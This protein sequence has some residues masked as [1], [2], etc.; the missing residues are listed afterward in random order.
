M[1]VSWK[2][3]TKYVDMPMTE[4]ELAE[5]LSLTGLNHEG[6]EK[7]NGDISIDLEV[8]SN[9]GDCLGH[10]G[11]A[12]EISVLYDLPLNKP[13][14]RPVENADSVEASIKVSN[15]FT[16][17]CPRY[18]ARVIRGAKVGPSPDWLVEL[19]QS[20]HWKKNQKT[21]SIETYKPINNIVDITN[22]VLY[23]C[24]QPLH[25]F[26]LAKIKGQE[27][28]VRPARNGEVITA[29][30]HASYTL[31]PEMCVIADRD[32]AVAVAGVMG[33]ADTEV[34]EGTTDLLIES[35]VFTPLSVRRTARKLKLHSPSSFRFERKVDPEGV[36]WASRRC[37]ELILEIAGGTLEA[38]SVDT[39]PKIP[40]RAPIILRPQQVER[41]LGIR[42][43]AEEIRDILSSL[44]CDEQTADVD[45]IY[46]RPPS[47]RHD[48]S[49][50]VDL[51]E[52][53][54]RIHGYDKI[55]DDSPIPTTAS[56]KR[57]H[58][59]AT[60]K[61]RA[62]L[63]S[64]GLSEAMTPSVVPSETDELV[65]PWSDLPALTTETAMLEGAKT[66]RRSIIP[67]L[68]KSRYANQTQKVDAELFE[69]AHIYVPPASP[70]GL[71]QEQY[72]VAG[73]S[74]R[75]FYEVKGI[76]MTLIQRLGISGPLAERVVTIPGLDKTWTIEISLDGKTLGFVGQLCPDV[77]AGLKL[78]TIP[79]VFELSLPTLLEACELVPQSKHVST[80]PT[81]SRDLN[82]IVDEAVRWTELESSVRSSL[83][84][85]LIGLHYRETYR[86]A[87][88][89]GEGKKANLDEH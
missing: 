28:V 43:P 63:T 52:E 11:V 50:E 38:G 89:D 82:L 47:W 7:V 10:I 65:S 37:C 57:P 53:V 2:W 71:P 64:A 80:M 56:Q 44:G 35:A 54:A 41:L 33:G 70:D 74:G 20:A 13:D 40:E 32:R 62:V 84:P 55:P 46:T 58:D 15:V 72:C 1:L 36:Q 69:I 9:R 21:G 88:K 6:T 19:L 39:D 78:D 42:I 61:I 79:T 77:V 68:L 31:A 22:Y 17:A 87:S 14:P 26:D 83:G 24:G 23:E 81:I 66:I 4:P 85:E 51:I 16:D 8:T 3:L 75:G 45:K 5:R 12:R 48:L 60:E 49:R 30:D 27:I 29:I 59:E 25:A 34:T 73:A 76:V 67:S 18:T 86:D